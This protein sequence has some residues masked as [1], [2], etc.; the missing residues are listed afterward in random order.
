MSSAVAMLF[1]AEKE[2]CAT[3]KQGAMMIG[4]ALIVAMYASGLPLP[5]YDVVAF[6][7]DLL[8]RF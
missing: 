6:D 4:G 8:K 7:R 3:F 1:S 5:I 2:Y